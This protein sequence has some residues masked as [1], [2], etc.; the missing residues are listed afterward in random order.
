MELINKKENQVTFKA[1]ISDSLAN[2][3][4]RYVFHI[5]ILAVEEIEVI[6]NDSP[7]YD[8]ILAHRI[9]LIPL[10]INGALTDKT[11][12]ILKLE[13]DKEGYV[14]SK[15][16]VDD[17]GKV[18]IVYNNMPIT[19]LNKGNK[20]KIKAFARAGIGKEHSKFSPGIIF[21]REIFNVKL[22]K[23]CPLEIIESCPKGVFEEKNGKVVIKDSFKCDFCEECIT[24]CQRNNLEEIK[25]EPTNELLI[26]VESFGQISC[27]EIFTKSIDLLKK[28]LNAVSKALK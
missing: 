9:G 27:K 11:E 18:S 15:E 14:Y 20:L 28:D 23:D 3:I 8:E 10:K 13:K 19:F 7:L 26:T 12:I 6:S 1:E 21:Y 4:R 22:P 24:F 5:P 2:A 16:L 25:I 17:S